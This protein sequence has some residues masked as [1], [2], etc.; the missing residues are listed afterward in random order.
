MRVHNATEC[1]LT[2]GQD[3]K[4]YVLCI[5]PQLEKNVWAVKRP[6]SV[7]STSWMN[8]LGPFPPSERWQE[9]EFEHFRFEEGGKAVKYS[10]GQRRMDRKSLAAS[11]K[12]ARWWSPKE[13]LHFR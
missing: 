9:R 4:F 3:G 6:S 2:N 5:L 7:L 1:M 10:G 12:Q 8:K 11:F 13:T